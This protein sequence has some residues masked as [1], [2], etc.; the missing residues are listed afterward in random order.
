M[1]TLSRLA[2]SVLSSSSSP[3]ALILSSLI[4][5]LSVLLIAGVNTFIVSCQDLTKQ[6]VFFPLCKSTGPDIYPALCYS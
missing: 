2:A 4:H 1:I 5:P 6:G 3:I